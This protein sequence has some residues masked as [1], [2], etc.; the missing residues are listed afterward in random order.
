MCT[1]VKWLGEKFDESCETDYAYTE[2]KE[3][4]FPGGGGVED[5]NGSKEDSFGTPCG[6]RMMGY[7]GR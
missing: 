6:R 5:V 1:N 4:L 7:I 2:S 3:W